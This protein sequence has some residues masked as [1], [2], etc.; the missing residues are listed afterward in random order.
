MEQQAKGEGHVVIQSLGF[1]LRCLS[2]ALS[3]VALS[4]AFVGCG[5]AC[6]NNDDDR[7]KRLERIIEEQ[8][9]RLEDQQKKSTEQ[10]A[11]QASNIDAPR[12]GS[13]RRAPGGADGIGAGLA[14]IARSFT[15]KMLFAEQLGHGAWDSDLERFRGGTTVNVVRIILPD[16]TSILAPADSIQLVQGTVPR[17][18]EFKTEPERTE[19]EQ[20]GRPRRASPAPPP[21]RNRHAARTP[22]PAARRPRLTTPP[23]G[24]GDADRAKSEQPVDQLLIE[25]GAILLKPRTLQVE[26]SFDYSRFSSDRVAI[27]G[28]HAVRSDHHRHDPRRQ[29]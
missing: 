27:N 26:P 29:P 21:A 17:Q 23:P 11:A 19:P 25:R 7:I 8:Q 3:A 12:R 10:D 24:A 6:A 2:T 28:H 1:A 13:G 4:C 16:G 15:A 18:P 20:P 14:T 22:R 9:K 5:A